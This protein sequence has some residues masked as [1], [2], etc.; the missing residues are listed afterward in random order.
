MIVCLFLL[1]YLCFYLCFYLFVYLF[2]CLPRVHEPLPHPVQA[3]AQLIGYLEQ[4]NVLFWE[5]WFWT[6][7]WSP[8]SPARGWRCPGSCRSG[9]WPSR[10]ASA[11]CW[12]R[13]SPTS[14]LQLAPPSLRTSWRRLELKK[15]WM[16]R[17]SLLPWKQQKSR[18]TFTFYDFW[19]NW[20]VCV[21][22]RVQCAETRQI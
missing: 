14:T 21:Y 20:W 2:V 1:F 18:F 5:S 12:R 4:K 6:R 19:Q 17:H 7:V 11:R 22:T 8:V 15:A 3:K 16:S 13:S 9:R 10:S